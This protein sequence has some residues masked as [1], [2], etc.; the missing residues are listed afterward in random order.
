MPFK[1]GVGYNGPR[2]GRPKGAKS[3]V[4]RKGLDLIAAQQARNSPWT[5]LEYALSILG[6]E[7]LS[8]AKRA[9][10]AQAAFPYVHRRM[11]LAIEGGDPARPIVVASA[12]QLRTLSP[13]ELALLSA[14]S[15]KITGALPSPEEFMKQIASALAKEVIEEDEVEPKPPKE[16]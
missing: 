1:K 12:A 5:P 11:P 9:W 7:K 10:A 14:M 15:K 3:K 2:T 16:K 4:S 6:N 8:F 13:E